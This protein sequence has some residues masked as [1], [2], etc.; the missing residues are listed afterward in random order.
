MIT[1]LEL[2]IDGFFLA[3]IVMSFLSTYED[4]DGVE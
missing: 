3:D 1:Y 2:L 4:K